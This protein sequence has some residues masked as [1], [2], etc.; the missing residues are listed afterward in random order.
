MQKIQKNMLADNR[1]L[2][3]GVWGRI[4]VDPY[5]DREL[6]FALCREA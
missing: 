3:A 6:L 5:L 1:R 2:V 4:R